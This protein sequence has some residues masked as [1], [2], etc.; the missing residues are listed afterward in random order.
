MRRFILSILFLSAFASAA[1]AAEVKNAHPSQVG[2]RILF[3]YDLAGDGEADVA[4]TIFFK[5]ETLTADKLHLEGD[6]GKVT[7]GPGKKIWWN[8]LQDFPRG[9]REEFEWEIAVK[10]SRESA[11]Y[12]DHGDGTVTDKKTGLMWQQRDD[13]KGRN[14][15][16]AKLY[17]NNLVLAGSSDWR[18]PE[19]D[20]LAGLVKQGVKPTIDN[21]YFP[22]TIS[23]CY[24]SSTTDAGDSSSAWCVFFVDGLG[25][26]VNSYYKT[27]DFNFRCVRGAEDMSTS[28]TI[29]PQRGLIDKINMAENAL[30]ED[31][32][33]VS[34]LVELGNL[35]MDSSRFQE[36]I[37]AY[38]KAL[39]IKPDNVDV[40]VD[41]GTCYRNSGN[42]R[43]AIKEYKKAIAYQPSN[44]NARLNMGVV[45]AFDLK[46]TSGAIKVWEEFLRIAPDHQMSPQIRD[47]IEKLKSA[48][49]K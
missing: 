41:I 32:E 20:E 48:K 29:S 43:R 22:D 14:W 4:V 15:E 3:E 27:G 18:L 24:W 11:Q 44:A 10:N 40:R 42:P 39:K 47:E 7:T 49:A 45:L 25:G 8:V 26:W 30:R 5:G 34:L 6:F 35:L 38:E 31:P 1:F 37:D 33:D 12:I 13:G 2:N 16:N 9:L 46:D 28:Q 19:K 21:E 17:C 36:A 23:S